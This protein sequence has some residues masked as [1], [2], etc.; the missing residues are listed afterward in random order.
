MGG[1]PSAPRR[2]SRRAGAAT[3]T[4]SAVVPV[5][6]SQALSASTGLRVDDRAVLDGT[7]SISV[8]VTGIVT[9][10]IGTASPVGVWADLAT[11]Q[12]A[13]LRTAP[14]VAAANRI[15]LAADDPAS[16]A[17][18]VA[19]AEPGAEVDPSPVA[20]LSRFSIPA[21]VA[22]IAGAAGALLF[23]LV[24]IGAATEGL[25]RSRR[26]EILVLRA[27]GAGQ[28]LQQASLRGELVAALVYAVVVGA[29]AAVVTAIA[30]VPALAH[31]A[32]PGAGPALQAGVR[33]EPFGLVAAALVLTIAGAV[34]FA[35]LSGAVRRAAV[36]GAVETRGVAR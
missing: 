20:V 17:E 18:R 35:V 3:G 23:A 9:H 13:L 1:R 7:P 19:T 14:E 27:L 33:V 26:D 22:L 29:I 11:L 16:A 31:A 21:T 24:G 2:R 6:L 8:R 15:W 4:G 10:T 28:G 34:A 5:V 30:T 25:L 32:D 12:L 36:T